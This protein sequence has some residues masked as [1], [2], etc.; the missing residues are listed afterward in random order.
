MYVCLEGN[1]YLNKIHE[2]SKDW[3]ES[4]FIVIPLRLGLNYIEPEYLSSVKKVFT[5]P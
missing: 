3:S 4:V 2:K 5:F 1:I